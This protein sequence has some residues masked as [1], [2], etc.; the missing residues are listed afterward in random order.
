MN[1]F[2]KSKWV[3]F[4]AATGLGLWCV[5]A[6]WRGGFDPATAHSKVDGLEF[7]KKSAFS[8]IKV[9]KVKN[10]RIL[11]FVHD[12]GEEWAQSILDLDRP[13]D[14]VVEY[15][16]MMFLSYLLRPHPEKVLIVGLGGGCLVHFLRH[17]DPQV[18]IDIVEID[19][20]VV[21]VADRFFGVGTGG[22]VNI[23]TQDGF[24]FFKTA[25]ATYDVIYM[26]AFLKPSAATDD[27]GVDLRLKTTKFYKEVQEKLALDGVVVF[28]INDHPKI[29][30]DLQTIRASFRSVYPFHVRRDGGWS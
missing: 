13:H 9:Y 21:E 2:S 30:Q 6:L 12:D 24:D 17:Y 26:D 5:F 20:V 19:P 11:R 15:S 23:I 22:N 27:T 1:H 16:K 28:N 29:K 10:E 8:H 25:Q 3:L 14:M 18:K 4:L 7:D